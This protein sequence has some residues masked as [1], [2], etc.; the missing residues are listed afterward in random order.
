MNSA[1]AKHIGIGIDTARYGHHV[2]FMDDQKRQAAKPFHFNE[3]AKGYQSLHSAIEQLCQKQPGC[4]L[5]IHVDAAG[6]YAENLLQ[7]LSKQ[8]WPATVVISVGQPARNKAYRKAHYDKRKADPIESLACA[9]FGVI[10]RPDATFQPATEFSVLRDAVAQMEASATNRARLINQL[11]NMLARAFPELAVIVKDVSAKSILKLLELYPTAERIAAAPIGSLAK[12]PHIGPELA[13]QLHEAAK[14]ST[15]ANRNRTT[16]QLIVRKVQSILAELRVHD[17]LEEITQNVVKELPTGPHRHV[18][19]IPGIGPQTEAALLA[20]IVSIERFRSANALIGYFGVFPEEVDVS[21]TNKDGS[22][23]TGKVT[24][25]SRKGNDLV[26]RLL[27][28]AAQTAIKHNPPVR[29]LYARV[30]AQGKDY[31]TAIG[32]CMAKLLRQVFAVWTKDCDFDPNCENRS[33]Q[34]LP[35][36]VALHADE[37]ETLTSEKE[38]VAGHSQAQGPSRKVVTA[39]E[40]S[41]A[42]R[43][44]ALNFA[45]LRSRVAMQDVLKLIAWT[46]RLSSNASTQRGHCPVHQSTNQKETSFVVDITKK[47]YCCHRCGSEGNVL[48][49]WAATQNLPL[50]DAAWNL[51]DRLGIDPPLLK[52]EKENHS[53]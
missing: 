22:P 13:A 25:M 50:F 36:A 26:R 34:Q 1:E 41:I 11:H 9:R 38:S 15:A 31:N 35:P 10:E 12:L 5:H 17:E 27:Y 6:Q 44:P 39:T 2:S 52:K 14:V 47:A 8:Q 32:H 46:G 33:E 51:V 45:E 43:R 4:V 28:T 16:Q 21:G 53:A 19:S 20:K 24:I 7:W 40:P 42:S 37:K 18:R 49:L 29:A 23:K 3:D 30:R 48:D